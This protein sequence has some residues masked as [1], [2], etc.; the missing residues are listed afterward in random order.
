MPS[1][2]MK[3]TNTVYISS[4]DFFDKPYVEIAATLVRRQDRYPQNADYLAPPPGYVSADCTLGADIMFG[5][6]P[7]QCSVTVHNLFNLAY[8]DYLSR[9]RYYIDDPGRDIVLRL[10]VPFGRSDRQFSE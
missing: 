9:F 1:D 4:S 2:R 8:R 6:Q 5:T 7:M 3:L 10:N